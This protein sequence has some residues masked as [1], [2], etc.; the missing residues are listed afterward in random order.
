[1]YWEDQLL[2]VAAGE[3]MGSDEQAAEKKLNIK[4]ELKQKLEPEQNGEEKTNKK[5]F[6]PFKTENET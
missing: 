6:K 5:K 1:M 2:S 3:L 4:P